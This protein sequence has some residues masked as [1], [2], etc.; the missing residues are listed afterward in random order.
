MSDSVI[1]TDKKSETTSNSIDFGSISSIIGLILAAFA[2]PNVPLTPLPPPLLAVGSNLRPGLSTSDI[3]SRIIS[4]QS[5]AGLVVG[6][7]FEDGD[8][9]AEKMELIR[10]EEIIN[11]IQTEAK[12][13]I[14]I[15]PGVGIAGV[16]FGNLGAPVFIQGVT[17]A[18]ASGKG[19][20][21]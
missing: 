13:E 12:I 18:I 11:A 6:D 9:T 10:I 1:N 17:T 2:I 21:R 20:I 5:E 3:A 4:R 16:G 14:A 19:V 15:L 7:V 8:N